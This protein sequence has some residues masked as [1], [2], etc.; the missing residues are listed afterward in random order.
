MPG[1]VP[2]KP[3]AHNTNEPIKRF[4]ATLAGL[5][6]G[7]FVGGN[8][9]TVA[10]LI[11]YVK[12]G[13]S[14]GEA[15]INQM[16]L[17]IVFAFA[18]MSAVFAGWVASKK[19]KEY[20][21]VLLSAA[22]AILVALFFMLEFSLP[23]PMDRTGSSPPEARFF[24][25]A[26]YLVW[27][28]VL[29]VLPALLLPDQSSTYDSRMKSAAS[30][31]AAAAGAAFVGFVFGHLLRGTVKW[32]LSEISWMQNL[33]RDAKPF[34]LDQ[35]EFWIANPATVSPVACAFIAIAFAPIWRQK[36][37]RV[38]D[39]WSRLAWLASF[40]LFAIVWT[41]VFGAALYAPSRD[42]AIA[43]RGM[44][45]EISGYTFFYAFAAYATALVLVLPLAFRLAPSSARDDG[46]AIPAGRSFWL[47]ASGLMFLAYTVVTWFGIGRLV[48]EFG[49]PTSQ[50]W[51]LSIL[52]GAHGIAIVLSLLFAKLVVV[53][54]PYLKDEQAV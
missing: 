15:A 13:S 23:V 24:E 50:R 41:G 27:A 4:G 52:H 1:A 49:A 35:F 33:L 51:V 14:Y 8:A 53:K 7:Q 47:L 29:L 16:S 3:P 38:G 32:Y 26:Y 42:W 44:N 34:A 22:S 25:M 28:V 10:K 37:W 48:A 2:P 19:W 43:L 36:L 39:T 45:T 21:S 9:K 40:S 6:L 18:M 5:V 20:E 30:L 54:L 31:I 12:D 46:I 17:V 11:L